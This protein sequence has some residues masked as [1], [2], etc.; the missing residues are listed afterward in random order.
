METG[1]TPTDG[2]WTAFLKAGD[3]GVWQLTNHT[4]A[5]GEVFELKVE[6]RN[7]GRATTL[8]IVLYYDEAGARTWAANRAVS[9]TDSMQEYT[10]MFNAAYAPASIGKQLGIEFTNVTP[11]PFSWLGLDNVRLTL[12]Q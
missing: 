4:L 8:S 11:D 2:L 3:P 1:Y 10:L 7:N 9:V 5:P 6:A 12:V